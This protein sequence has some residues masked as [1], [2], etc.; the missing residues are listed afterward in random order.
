VVPDDQPRARLELDDA[1][2]RGD[3]DSP[4]TA[5]LIDDQVRKRADRILVEADVLA[6]QVGEGVAPGAVEAE[7][8][9]EEDEWRL[10]GEA[11]ALRLTGREGQE[12]MHAVAAPDFEPKKPGER[13]VE[14][15]V[16]GGAETHVTDDNGPANERAGPVKRRHSIG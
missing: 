15:R 13:P 11:I 16:H 6:P 12:A 4:D 5:L 7:L 1:P 9:V 8:T 3:D 10:D 2:R 14:E